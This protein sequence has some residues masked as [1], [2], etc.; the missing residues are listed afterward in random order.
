M[1]FGLFLP[2]YIFSAIVPIVFGIIIVS[3]II[4]S[5][6]GNNNTSLFKQNQQNLNQNNDGNDYSNNIDLSSNVKYCEYCGNECKT[7]ENKCK[8]CGA[9][10]RK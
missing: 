5:V 7:S 8:S 4:K 1:G 6:K 9:K 2:I 3:S 10:L